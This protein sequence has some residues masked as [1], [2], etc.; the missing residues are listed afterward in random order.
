MIAGGLLAFIALAVLPAVMDLS[1]SSKS[2]G[3][4][5]FCTAAVR[6]KLQEYMNGVSDTRL[7]PGATNYVPTGFEYSKRRYQASTFAKSG[8]NTCSLN[9]NAGTPGYR[10]SIFSNSI[11]SD[12]AREFD[13]NGN[14]VSGD[15]MGFQI[16]VMLR[17]Y[18]PRVLTD[19]NQPSRACPGTSYQFLQVGD[20]IEVTVTGMM[21][22][23]PLISQGGRSATTGANTPY[24]SLKDVNSTTPN[25]YLTCSVTD[26]VYPPI[27]PFRYFLAPDGFLYN[28]QAKLSESTGVPGA[29]IHAAQAHFRNVWSISTNPAGDPDSS[30]RVPNTGIKSIA[31]AP[32]NKFVWVMRSGE[33][34]RYGP[35]TETGSTVNIG[36]VNRSFGG[37]VS[38]TISGVTQGFTGMPDCPPLPSINNLTIPDGLVWSAPINLEKIAVNFK[39][40]DVATDDAIYGI[41]NVGGAVVSGIGALQKATLTTSVPYTA[42]FADTADFTIPANRPRIQGIFITQN[43]PAVT[44]PSLYF[45]DN[46]C[47]APPGTLNVQTLRY[48][49]SIYTGSDTN[50][51]QVTKEMPIQVEAVSY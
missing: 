43:Y 38:V 51:Q 24:G 25:P 50:M 10:E 28:L 4:K 45:F 6:A 9:P 42:T 17:H 14:P 37:S 12:T 29:T 21:R 5:S 19:G 11:I 36:G 27:L 49:T 2:T 3:F 32:N 34:S 18:N 30:T 8:F 41:H 33:L 23:Y 16:W 13:A 22:T 47:Y 44:T 26:V 1:K 40:A 20:A 15:Q 39:E 46:E 35:C 31:I 7:W 48:C